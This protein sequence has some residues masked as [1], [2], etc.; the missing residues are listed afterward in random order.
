MEQERVLF[1]DSKSMVVQLTVF[2]LTIA[3]TNF[4]FSSARLYSRLQYFVTIQQNQATIP[5]DRSTCCSIKG[6][7]VHASKEDTPIQL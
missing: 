4:D 7:I 3:W 6:T 5:Q 2:S 1:H